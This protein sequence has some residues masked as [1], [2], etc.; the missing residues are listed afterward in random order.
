MAKL[1]QMT[2]KT[3]AG[4]IGIS[5]ER[6]RGV[7]LNHL[8]LGTHFEKTAAGIVYSRMGLMRPWRRYRPGL[9][10]FLNSWIKNGVIPFVVKTPGGTRI[11]ASALQL[12]AESRR[13]ETCLR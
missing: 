8:L 5:R 9:P 13:I 12:F 2:E 10:P 11:P 3:A 4:Q 1:Y 6:M 7:R